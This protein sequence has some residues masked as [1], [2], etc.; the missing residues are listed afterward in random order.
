MAGAPPQ[1]PTPLTQQGLLDLFAGDAVGRSVVLD[2]A[3]QADMRGANAVARPS[4]EI[5]YEGV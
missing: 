1:R 2:P 4:L 3:T 5:V